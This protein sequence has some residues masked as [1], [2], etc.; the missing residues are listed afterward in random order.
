MIAWSYGTV[1]KATKEVAIRFDTVHVGRGKRLSEVC[2]KHQMW[3]VRDWKPSW[4]WHTHPRAARRWTVMTGS[5]DPVL[6]T[7]NVLKPRFRR[8]WR[9]E[10]LANVR[11]GLPSWIP[12]FTYWKLLK[13]PVRTMIRGVEVFLSSLVNVWIRRQCWRGSG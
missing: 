3:G 7:Y 12:D 10:P 11:N 5:I 2:E 9:N 4:D 13:K 6:P 8:T 1:L